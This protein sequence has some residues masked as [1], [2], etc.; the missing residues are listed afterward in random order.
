MSWNYRV[1]KRNYR[2]RDFFEIYEAF[3]SSGN[4]KP[5]SYTTNPMT[6]CGESKEELKEVLKMMLK[7][8]DKPVLNYY[9]DF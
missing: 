6:P 1:Y 3:Y 7:A 8:L 4:P 9:E 5:D 2:G